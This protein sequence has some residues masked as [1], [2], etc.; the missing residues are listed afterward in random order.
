M[1]R[2][3]FIKVSGATYYEIGKDYGRQARDLIAH[4]VNDYKQVFAYTSGTSLRVMSTKDSA[5][6][7]ISSQERFEVYAKT[8]L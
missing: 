3:P 8:R 6:F 5:N 7:W 4:A 2:Y 1:L